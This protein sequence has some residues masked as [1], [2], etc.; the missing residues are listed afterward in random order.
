[1]ATATVKLY[2]SLSRYLPDG[3]DKNTIQVVL[4]PAATVTSTLAGLQVPPGR[5]HLVL[6]NG[7]FVSPGARA[8]RPVAD[9]DVIAVW[10]P[11][12]GG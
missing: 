1:M 6:V 2:A 12:A 5:C 3:A 4:P 8:S 10:P 11:V 9:G 7:V